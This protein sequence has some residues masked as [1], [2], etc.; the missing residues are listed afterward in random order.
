[1]LIR[2]IMFE[3]HQHLH[4]SIYP[5]IFKIKTYDDSYTRSR[6]RLGHVRYNYRYRQ[7]ILGSRVQMQPHAKLQSS[8]RGFFFLLFLFHNNIKLTFS[9][10]NTLSAYFYGHYDY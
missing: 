7:R 10:V 8:N 5:S 3:N 1:M 9:G 6:G 4:F 2:T